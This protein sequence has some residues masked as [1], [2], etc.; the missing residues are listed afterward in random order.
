M[1]EAGRSD[2]DQLID[3][4]QAKAPGEPYFVVFAHDPSAGDTV[5]AWASLSH[6][7]GVPVAQVESALQ[8]ADALDAWPEKR[9]PN[10]RHLGAAE[11]QNLGH[12]FARRAWQARE[13]CA[14]TRIMFAE[15]RAIAAALGRVRPLLNS[16][17]NHCETQDDGSVL[18]RR[19]NHGGGPVADHNDPLLGLKRLAD[20]LRA[21]YQPAAL[22]EEPAD[23]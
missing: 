22:P 7:K 14:D 17:L 21:L 13:D 8:Q 18:Y 20:V 11:Q 10:A 9:L 15:E 19:P 23:A 4:R 1:P 2:Y 12:A 3:F 16:F 6:R 5:R